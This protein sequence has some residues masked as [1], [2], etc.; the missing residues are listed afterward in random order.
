M[1]AQPNN[2][3][4]CCQLPEHPVG[5]SNLSGDDNLAALKIRLDNMQR[6]ASKY[7]DNMQQD[8]LELVQ[9]QSDPSER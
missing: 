9:S 7:I 5:Y 2:S 1:K 3:C 8:A 4:T 6:A